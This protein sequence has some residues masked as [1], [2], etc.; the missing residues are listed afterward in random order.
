MVNQEVKGLT[1]REVCSMIRACKDA[2]LKSLTWG[3]LDIQFWGEVQSIPHPIHVP[4]ATVE[5]QRAIETESIEEQELSLRQSQLEIL[6]IENPG[7]YERLLAQGEL[8]EGQGTG[9]HADADAEDFGS[10]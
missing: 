4:Q 2:G 9:A 10:Q 7:E 1:A 8:T 6:R 5:R 3:D